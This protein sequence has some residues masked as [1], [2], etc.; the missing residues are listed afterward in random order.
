MAHEVESLMY[1]REV[2]WHGLGVRVEESPNS[3]D[4]IKIAGLDWIVEPKPIFDVNQ[5]QIPGFVANTRSTDGSVLGIVSDKYKIVQNSE[6]FKF[7]DSLIGGDVRYETAGSLRSGKSI[8][9]LAHL[10]HTSILGDEVAP[11][12][13]FTST[14]DGTGAIKVCMTPIRVVCNNTLNLALNKARRTWTCRHMGNLEDK[15]AEATH[16]LGLA[17]K[18]MQKLSVEADRLANTSI[19]ND[20][21][22]EILDELFPIKEE[23]SDRIKANTTKARNEFM[24]AYYMPDIAKFQGTA[25]GL[26]NAA[27]DFMGH[28]TP[29]RNT[30]TYNERNFERII[31]GHPILD[32]VVNKFAVKA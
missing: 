16:T 8:F 11:Y 32:A 17:N 18:Y 21:I 9:L 6:A 20:Q 10:P 14:H 22:K 31:Y 3:E 27:S 7:T 24:V 26:V 2:P 13:C 29:Q 5:I 30:S 23:D 12:L 28:V 1:T 4:A 25:W 19:T 15:L